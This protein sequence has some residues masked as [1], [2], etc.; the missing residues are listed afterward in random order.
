VDATS[1]ASAP[2]AGLSPT[3]QFAVLSLLTIGASTLVFGVALAYF[4]ERGIL[5][6]EWASTAALVQAATRFHLRPTDFTPRAAGAA[7]P[8]EADDRFEELTRQV[9]MLP[10]VLRL[11]VY[12]GHGGVLWADTER[13]PAPEMPGARLAEAL[14]GEVAVHL[15]PASGDA[16]ERVDL[17]VP[18]RFPGEGRVAGV[19]LAQVDASRVLATV[20]RAR[21]ALWSLALLSG[22]V[23]YGV[24]YG[25]VWRASRRL[26]AQH[27]ALGRRAEELASANAEMRA[28]QQQLVAAERLAAF[29]EITAAV[30]HGLGTPLAAIK[31]LAQL[32]RLDA[33]AGPLG[34]R[35]DQVVA[36][37]D[38]LADRM[39]ALLRYG[40]PVEQRRVPT[41]LDAAVGSAL[42]GLR[43]RCAARR[44]TL[45]VAVPADLPKVRLDP[46]RFEEALLCLAGNAL[47]AMP[48]GGQLRVAAA[49][50]G[51]ALQ[52]VVED[53]GPGIPPAVLARVFEPFFTTKPNGT[54]LGLA[55]AKKLLEGAGGRL[56]L[57]SEP[58]RGTRAVITLPVDDA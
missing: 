8:G 58:G 16:A 49:A 13:P 11:T 47:E 48:S 2:R 36:E 52:L 26:Q 30:A 44:V 43:P 22:L 40:R 31:A 20:R 56:A 34:D 24:L 4:A 17:Y 53:T 37:T 23:L 7:R 3:R 57:T 38:R 15:Q 12:D 54:G 55:I 46:A 51:A 32:A 41:A 25:I 18:L 1:A 42:D 14:A 45:D 9:R 35:L 6:R 29:G 50:D 10:D 28:L 27:A 33:P 21:L 19:V 5:D 39:R